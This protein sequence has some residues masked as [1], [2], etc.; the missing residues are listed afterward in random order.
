MDLEE[1]WSEDGENVPLDIVESAK[2]VVL[3]LLPDKSKE[4]YEQEYDTFKKW[5]N[6]NHVR[7]INEDAV[8]VY[9]FKLSKTL[10]PSTL[11]SK[12]SMVRSCVNIKDNIDIKYPKLIAFL[13]KQASWY[14]PRKSQ[15]FTREEVNKFISQAP[16]EKIVMLSFF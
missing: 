4:R 12:Y 16:D 5:M 11:W 3:D 2:L 9:F 1:N 10:K 8:L 6:K 14:K 13:K 15:I 7:K